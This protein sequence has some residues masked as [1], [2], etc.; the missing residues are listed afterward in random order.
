[1]ERLIELSL[2][3]LIGIGIGFCIVY[4]RKLIDTL[5]EMRLVS[6]GTAFW[7]LSL[8]MFVLSLMITIP[9]VYWKMRLLFPISLLGGLPIVVAINRQRVSEQLQPA[10]MLFRKYCYRRKMAPKALKKHIS[11]FKSR[12]DM[13][14]WLKTGW[15]LPNG[16]PLWGDYRLFREDVERFLEENYVSEFAVWQHE[17]L[18]SYGLEPLEKPEHD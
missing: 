3:L 17:V 13:A 16:E 18:K 10:I 12:E 9:L 11:G 1:M 5:V 2:N 7:C 15:L 14:D 6:A 8:G 4:L